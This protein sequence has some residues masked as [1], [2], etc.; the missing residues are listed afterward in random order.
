MFI[1]LVIVCCSHFS[2]T[3]SPLVWTVNGHLQDFVNGSSYYLW[4]YQVRFTAKAFNLSFTSLQQVAH[5][6][7][8]PQ[9]SSAGDQ[10]SNT[11]N[12]LRKQTLST[13]IELLLP[14]QWS[15][16]LIVNSY[17]EFSKTSSVHL[18]FGLSHKTRW[19]FPS[20]IIYHESLCC[21]TFLVIIRIPTLMAL[22]LI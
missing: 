13:I 8:L 9:I 19:L 12:T 3:R 11:E 1:V 2:V 16:N 6:V 14:R 18:V 21:S 22:I 17:V 4:M 15:C 7:D 5:C 20:L 10:S